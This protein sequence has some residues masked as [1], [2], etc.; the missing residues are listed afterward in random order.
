MRRPP[1]HPENAGAWRFLHELQTMF[2]QI[3]AK[4]YLTVSETNLSIYVLDI[5]Y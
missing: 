3:P 5:I 1:I 4:A 2:P